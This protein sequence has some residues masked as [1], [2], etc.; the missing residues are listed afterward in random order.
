MNDYSI[1]KLSNG[2]DLICRVVNNTDSD[3]AGFQFDV[4]GADLLGA[5][6]G[7]ADAIGTW[8]KGQLTY[9]SATAASFS[10]VIPDGFAASNSEEHTTEHQTH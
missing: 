8:A 2:E 5:S 10:L 4:N 1:L 6:D 9:T 3:I 7:D